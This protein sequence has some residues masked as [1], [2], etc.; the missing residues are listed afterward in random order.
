M[1]K[2]EY[3]WWDF[4]GGLVVELDWGNF[5]VVCIKIIK[6]KNGLNVGYSCDCC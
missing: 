2:V 5:I 4:L 3:N 1:V 6:L